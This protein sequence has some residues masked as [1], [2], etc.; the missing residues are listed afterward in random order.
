MAGFTLAGT[1]PTTVGATVC[2]TGIIRRAE[3]IGFIQRGTHRLF[4]LAGNLIASLASTQVNLFGLEGR[5]VTVCGTSEGGIEGVL[6][7]NVTQVLPA[8]VPGAA[9][10][11]QP[12]P[13]IR[14]LLLLLLLTQPGLIRTIRPE[15]LLFLLLGRSF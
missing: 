1:G 8:T 9:P 13:D 7:L 10:T 5:F 2:R 4:D 15:L 3:E 14:L 11:P 12:Q 6:A